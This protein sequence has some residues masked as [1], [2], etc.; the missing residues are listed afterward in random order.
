MKKIVVS[1]RTGYRLQKHRLEIQVILDFFL[2]EMQLNS[3]ITIIL[4]AHL[5]MLGYLCAIKLQWPQ[6]NMGPG[7]A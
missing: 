6:N 2:Q 3:L 4:A 5:D 1:T 7:V